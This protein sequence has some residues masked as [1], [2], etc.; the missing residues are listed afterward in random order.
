[1]TASPNHELFVATNAARA[2]SD[3]LRA[4]FAG[5]PE[6]AA[7]MIEG[8]TTI[9]EALEAAAKAI[10]ED[11][12]RIASIDSMISNLATRKERIQA[13]VEIM[14]TAM[15]VALQEAAIKTKDCGFCTLSLKA[16]PPS[17]VITD[18]AAIPSSYWKATE[19]KLDKKAVLAALKG[20]QAVAGAELSNGGET[21]AIKWS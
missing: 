7:S 6:L 13:R 21:L 19:P 4:E 16:L 3:R 10:F 20:K 2:L 15:S 5:D 14:R 18:E 9:H 12:A 11:V 1:M 8:E 17:L